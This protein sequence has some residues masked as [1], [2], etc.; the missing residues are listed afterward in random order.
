LTSRADGNTFDFKAASEE[1]K[2]SLLYRTSEHGFLS[3]KFHD[4]C[5]NRGPTITMVKSEEGHI[6]AFYNSNSWDLRVA[7][8][9][10]IGCNR[11]LNPKGFIA[12]IVEDPETRGVYSLQKY[13]P[14]E[15]AYVLSTIYGGPNFGG[16]RGHLGIPNRC[17]MNSGYS[18]LQPGGRSSINSGGYT[19]VGMAEGM[20]RNY[21]FGT[22]EFGVSE[23]QVELVETV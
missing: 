16:H 7:L 20:P 5:D 22:W 23:F 11:V 19:S 1:V 21:L 17:D 8:G 10:Y 18:N 2:L 15:H 14:D 3:K 12:S 13:V 9:G 6:A 4:F